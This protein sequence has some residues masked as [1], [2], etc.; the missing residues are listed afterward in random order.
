[1]S[2]NKRKSTDSIWDTSW[3]VFTE[4]TDICRRDSE[5][6][7][8]RPIG[9]ESLYNTITEESDRELAK[10]SAKIIKS[11]YNKDAEST[12]LLQSNKLNKL[13]FVCRNILLYTIINLWKLN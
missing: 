9:L 1:M 3:S 7:R 8:R 6:V 11:I 5:N 10:P 2:T 12:I 4:S 13:K